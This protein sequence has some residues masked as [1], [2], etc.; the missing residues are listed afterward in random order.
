MSGRIK[1][2]FIIIIVIHVLSMCMGY[3]LNVLFYFPGA[4]IKTHYHG[5]CNIILYSIYTISINTLHDEG[6][7]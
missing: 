5:D 1:G 4:I 7:F 3:V 6:K 2:V